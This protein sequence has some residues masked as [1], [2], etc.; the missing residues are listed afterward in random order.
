MLDHIYI[1]RVKEVADD[2][3]SYKFLRRCP[4][5]CRE[6]GKIFYYRQDSKT[7]DYIYKE[8]LDNKPEFGIAYLSAP[9]EMDE[10]KELKIRA[11]E[12]R[13]QLTHKRILIEDYQNRIEKCQDDISNLLDELNTCLKELERLGEHN[14]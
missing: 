9:V 4:I 10:V 14:E 12:L 1:Y 11:I 13:Q 3:Y 5:L 7:V 8:G 2:I 6:D